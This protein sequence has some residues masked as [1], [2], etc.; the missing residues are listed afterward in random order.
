MVTGS[1]GPAGSVSTVRERLASWLRTRTGAVVAAVVAVALVASGASA[2]VL[3]SDSDVFGALGAGVGDG[4][5]TEEPVDCRTEVPSLTEAMTVAVACGTEVEATDERNAWQ[6]TFATPEGQVRLETG[7]EAIRSDVDGDGAWAQLDTSVSAAGDGRLEVAA[8]AMAMSFADGSDPDAPLVRLVTGEGETVDVAAPVALTEAVIDGDE[9][10]YPDVLPDGVDLVV[11]VNADGSGWSQALRFDSARA[12]RGAET[13]DLDLDDG[14]AVDAPGLKIARDNGA[15]TVL[16]D[17][18]GADTEGSRELVASSRP[19]V[20]T[21][22][23]P[24]AEPAKDGPAR[25]PVAAEAAP[26]VGRV[27]GRTRGRHLSY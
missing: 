22:E 4:E 15:F 26:P 8:P 20:L 17:E 9:V 24:T 10:T 16:D 18:A 19:A 7:T 13:I 23:Q 11:T 21:S 5:T 2:A 3:S 1:V 12:V 27:G 25:S 14:P 6:S